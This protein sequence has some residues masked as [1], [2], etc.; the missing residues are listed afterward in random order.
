MQRRSFISSRLDYCNSLLSG[1][2]NST[3]R[4]IQLVENAAARLLTRMRRFDHITS[5]LASLH[6]LPTTTR[7]DFEVL[8]LTYKALHGSAPSYLKDLIIHYSPSRPFRPWELAFFHNQRWKINQ[9]DR[10]RL[11]IEC[12]I[13]GIVCHLN[14]EKLIPL[15]YSKQSKKHIV[16][17]LAP[18]GAKPAADVGT[19]AECMDEVCPCLSDYLNVS[20]FSVCAVT[21]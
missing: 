20:D 21:K 18:R 17:S 9:Q 14:Q 4:S 16:F 1:L 6:W 8:L 13:Y 10:E 2:S 5:I 11:L 15:S 7:L 19:D 3:T 12:P